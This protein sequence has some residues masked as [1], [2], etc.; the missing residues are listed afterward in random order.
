MKAALALVTAK[1]KVDRKMSEKNSEDSVDV[2]EDDEVMA[3]PSPKTSPK[4]SPA[5]KSKSSSSS[6]ASEVKN[7]KRKK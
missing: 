3:T 1:G 4:S 2:G 5:P 6:L 7:N